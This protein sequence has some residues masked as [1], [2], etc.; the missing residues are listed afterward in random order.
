MMQHRTLLAFW[1]E[2]SLATDSKVFAA[3]LKNNIKR[4]KNT[5]LFSHIIDEL[6]KTAGS[7]L[8]YILVH[9]LLVFKYIWLIKREGY[10]S[11]FHSST[12]QIYYELEYS[13]IYRKQKNP[14]DKLH[15]P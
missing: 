4:G 5:V 2:I 3:T 11:L 14:V 12:E 15:E 9:S 6:L 7:I 13:F 1:L 10:F 8:W